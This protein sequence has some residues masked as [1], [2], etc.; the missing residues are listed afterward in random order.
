ME[1]KIGDFVRFVDENI[2]G[3]VTSIQSDILIGVTDESGFEIPVLKSKVTKVYDH[4]KTQNQSIP[5]KEIKQDIKTSKEEPETQKKEEQGDK[6]APD[7]TKP[8]DTEQTEEATFQ[9]EGI[10]LGVSLKDKNSA[11]LFIINQSSY[12]LLTSVSEIEKNKTKGIQAEK[13][14]SKRAVSFF[15][16]N[17]TTLRQWPKFYFQILRF[18]E[19]KENIT[20][21]I[22][23]EIRIKAEQLLV[24]PVEIPNIRFKGYLIPLDAIAKQEI[25]QKKENYLSHRPRSVGKESIRIKG[26]IDLSKFKK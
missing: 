2:E 9:A 6:P 25:N 21:P 4:R 23:K 17:Y 12:T 22:L 19:T 13:I 11:E 20:E 5:E 10:Y 7:N 3:Y 15:N 18:T 26:K 14:E 1:Y 24:E 16:G 8:I